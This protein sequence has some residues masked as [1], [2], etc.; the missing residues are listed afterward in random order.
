MSSAGVERLR[1]GRKRP[2]LDGR[3]DDLFFPSPLPNRA[4]V[5]GSDA[6]F[7]KGSRL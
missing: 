4:L 3:W 6:H 1:I 2:N 5:A 7:G